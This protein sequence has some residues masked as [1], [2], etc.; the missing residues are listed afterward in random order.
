MVSEQATA[1]PAVCTLECRHIELCVV[2]LVLVVFV[3]R[4]KQL[5]T[6]SQ[7]SCCVLTLHNI[8]HVHV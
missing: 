5:M 1:A 6:M 7:A 4:S 2:E 8:G 3:S